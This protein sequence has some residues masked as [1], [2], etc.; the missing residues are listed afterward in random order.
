L[1]F[2]DKYATIY[3]LL[4]I[5][6]LTYIVKKIKFYTNMSIKSLVIAITEK[7]NLKCAMCNIW[8]TENPV[9]LSLEKFE[10]LHNLKYINLSGGEPFLRS[11]LCDIV[12]ILKKN[13]PNSNIIISS[14]GLLTNQI[15]SLMKKLVFIDKNIGIR[16][17]I[18]GTEKIHNE[19]RGVEKSFENAIQTIKE[20]KENKIKN[21]GIA[22]T[23]S[24]NNKNE[25]KTVYDFS[26]KLGVEFS[27][28]SVQNSEIYFNK[29]DNNIF[30]DQNLENQINYIVRDQLKSWNMKKWLR[31]YFD[32]GLLYYLKNKKR[33]IPADS[34]NFS[35]FIDSKGDIY[36]SNLINEKI[37]N[38]DNFNS[39]N[40]KYKNTTQEH[41]SICNTR[42]SMKK[43]FYKVIYWIIK[44]KIK[45]LFK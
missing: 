24:N 43:Y 12:K 34:G 42:G 16:I 23:I 36:P 5:L 7:C 31:A 40:S 33:L 28:S 15:V 2:I 9:D 8:K 35:A 27:M 30:F 45:L 14:N 25:L 19:I 38:I 4:L 39:L 18:D 20:L 32:Y 6:F 17:S 21:I 37:A 29:Q 41:F 22:F 26:K 44:E 3:T 11:D 10:K 13:N 1:T